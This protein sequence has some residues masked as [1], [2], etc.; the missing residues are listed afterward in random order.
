MNNNVE[1][2]HM[3]WPP[4]SPCNLLPLVFQGGLKLKK[5][6]CVDG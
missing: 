4:S 1:D 6:I 2:V 3:E 5:Y